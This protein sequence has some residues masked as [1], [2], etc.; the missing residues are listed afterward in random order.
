MKWPSK[1]ENL[2]FFFDA[3]GCDDNMQWK[4]ELGAIRAMVCFAKATG[5][6]NRNPDEE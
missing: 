4:P 5:R 6:L 2:R 3:K 1:E